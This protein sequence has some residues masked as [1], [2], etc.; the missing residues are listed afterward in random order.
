MSS[1]HDVADNG[2]GSSIASML[3]RD[4]VC[5]AISKAV[6]NACLVP[7]GVAGKVELNLSLVDLNQ[8]HTSLVHACDGASSHP[9]LLTLTPCSPELKSGD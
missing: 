9:K 6:P 1:C 4:K 8:Y 2:A 3:I 5:K 7:R